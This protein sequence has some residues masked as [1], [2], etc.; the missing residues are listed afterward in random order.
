M[1]RAQG[2]H[3]RPQDAVA[4]LPTVTAPRAQA[5]ERMG[6]QSV[7]DLLRLAPRRYE[8]RRHPVAVDAL[9][10]QVPALVVGRVTRSKTIRARGGL[11]ILEA[12]VQDDSATIRARWFHRGYTPRPLTSGARV[13]LYGAPR[14]EGKSL[15]FH[16]PALERLPDEDEDDAPWEVPGAGRLVPVHPLTKGLTAP[17]VRGL[18]WR[19]LSACDAIEDWVPTEARESHDLPPL[20][21]VLRHLHFPPDEGAAE[22][23]RR[24]LAFD[25]LLLHELRLTRVR[26][27]NAALKGPRCATSDDVQERIDARLPF[28]LTAGQRAAVD[29]I[30]HDMASGRPMSRLL[31]GDVG[32]GKTAVAIYALLAAVAGGY[33][34]ALMAPTEILARQHEATLREFLAGSRV[35]L[36]FLTGGRATKARA[37]LCETIAA[38][39]VDLVVGTHAVLSESVSFQRLGLVVIDEQ[40]KFGVRQR[41]ALLDKGDDDVDKPH[42]LIMTAT[43]IPRTLALT[44]YG[45]LD[46]S[47]IEGTLPGRKPVET[48][49][50]KPR[51]GR[52]VMDRVRAHLERGHQAYVIYPLVEESDKLALKDAE[53]GLVR[54]QRALPDRTV[55]LVHGRMKKADKAA[56]MDAFRDGTA[57]VLVST[58]VVE[59]GVDVPNATV[60]VV[61]HAE[62]FGLSQLHQLR[63]R[64]GRGQHGGLCVL[65]D[66][67]KSGRPV[68]LDV[69]ASTQDGF[70]IAEEDLAL[71][72]IGDLMGTRQH[73]RPAFLAASLPRDLPLL[74]AARAMAESLWETAPKHAPLREAL[75]RSR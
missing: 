36:A 32:S 20:R 34:T 23:A 19:V 8:D 64:I 53:A 1:S 70:R 58:V 40:H 31:Q 45:D 68:R 67:A 41:A 75:L 17:Y 21:H 3:V 33:Q 60:L 65:M 51:E 6:I 48:I 10:A 39:D 11:S 22:V 47:V 46:V 72:G 44:L 71:R 15:V 49:V 50:A 73:G 35:R 16:A 25:E 5:F 7:E 27:R 12:D 26:K 4:D 24:R 56:A 63:G 29:D 74:Q 62:R 61:E 30:L 59:V 54:W 52:A 69:L 55:A 13:A 2:E 28:E 57:D 66:R 18:V 42:A 9:E 37:A 43:P 38:G 14:E